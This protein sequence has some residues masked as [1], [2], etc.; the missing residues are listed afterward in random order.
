MN[1]GLSLEK[2]ENLTETDITEELLCD[3]VYNNK[4]DRWSFVGVLPDSSYIHST[5]QSKRT[6]EEVTEFICDLKR[7]SDGSAPYFC[8]DCWFCEQAL[9]DNYCSYEQVPYKGRGRKPNPIQV[10]NPDLRHAQV[11][12]K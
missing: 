5:H 6:L 10:V 1:S 12:K 3:Q 4:G 7:Q 11:H 8:S 2:N 9:V